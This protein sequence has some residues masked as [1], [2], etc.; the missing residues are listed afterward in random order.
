VKEGEA[1]NKDLLELWGQTLLEM[2]KIAG[3]PQGFFDLFQ[4]GF[5]RREER[6]GS[7]HEQ[8]LEL[9]QRTFGKQGIEAFNSVMKE[10]YEN[11]GV[12]PLAH[13]NELHEKYVALK[14]RVQQLEGEIA[15]LRRKIQQQRGTPSDL[16]EQWSDTAKK[17]TEINQQFFEEFSKFFR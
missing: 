4:N 14:D 7:V 3:G 5:V 10:F 1:V 2:A 8:F 6:P 13:Y 17:Y 12:I 15:R 16:M 11:A 9:C